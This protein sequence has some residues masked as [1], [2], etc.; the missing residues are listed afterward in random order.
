MFDFLNSTR[1]ASLL[2]FISL[3]HSLQQNNIVLNIFI[4]NNANYNYE[5][6]TTTAFFQTY[7][8]WTVHDDLDKP[9][10]AR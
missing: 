7:L 10:I 4:A 5:L 6:Q 3:L 2:A 1:K 9:T 8:Y